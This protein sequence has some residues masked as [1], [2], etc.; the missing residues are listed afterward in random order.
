MKFLT[1]TIALIFSLNSFSQSRNELLAEI[2]SWKTSIINTA[3]FPMP[4]DSFAYTLKNYFDTNG[5]KFDSKTD[6]SVTFKINLKTY[7]ER[8]FLADKNYRHPL[9]NN[10]KPNFNMVD[11]KLYV[12]CVLYDNQNKIDVKIVSTYNNNYADKTTY[13]QDVLKGGSLAVPT[14]TNKQYFYNNKPFNFNPYDIKKYLFTAYYGNS[15]LIS[16][17]LQN[18]IILYNNKQKKEDKKI[19]KGRDY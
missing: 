4:I 13:N 19:V 9:H 18:K 11:I 5:Y 6:S 12:I 1:I 8:Q 15:F 16:E 7:A 14:V 2:N 17:E 10:A 3:C